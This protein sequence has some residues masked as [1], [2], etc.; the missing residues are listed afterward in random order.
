MLHVQE[1][2]YANDYRQGL[3]RI[4]GVPFISAMYCWWILWGIVL[5]KS[6]SKNLLRPLSVQ[7]LIAVGIYALLGLSY[8][9]DQRGVF[10]DFQLL[11]GFWA[12]IALAALTIEA[13]SS[14]TVHAVL[15]GLW[16]AMF[17]YTLYAVASRGYVIGRERAYDSIN[18]M[19]LDLSIPGVC[20]ILY[21]VRQLRHLAYISAISLLGA[22]L[23]ASTY[24]IMARA[25]VIAILAALVSIALVWNKDGSQLRSGRVSP[26]LTLGALGVATGLVIGWIVQQQELLARFQEDNYSWSENSRLS[27]VIKVAS[28]LTL[29]EVM[30]GKGLGYV[31]SS[32][33]GDTLGLHIGILTFVF[34]IGIFG[35]LFIGTPICFKLYQFLKA[36]FRPVIR[37]TGDSHAIYLIPAMTAYLVQSL[38]S[39]GYK[40]IVFIIIGYMYALGVNTTSLNPRNQAT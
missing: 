11:L 25:H 27:E 12:G 39:G 28:V 2:A 22:L 36:G 10:L 8:G 33:A 35:C 14:V 4:V 21:W 18:F 26:L 40:E 37:G 9:S 16:V 5:C 29:A 31:I 13:R 1:I 17:G 20:L 30:V 3:P 32:E 15:C 38:L 6:A 23:F 7:L 19:Y 24:V 34:K